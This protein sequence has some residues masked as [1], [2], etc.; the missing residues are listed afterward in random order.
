MLGYLYILHT[1]RDRFNRKL[2]LLLGCLLLSGCMSTHTSVCPHICPVTELFAVYEVVAIEKYRGGLT[3][4]IQAEALVDKEVNISADLFRMADAT[5]TQPS[6]Q[7][8]CHSTPN[9]GEV[10]TDRWSNFYGYKI[11]RRHI[12]VLDVFGNDETYPEYR[13]EVISDREL[14]WLHDGWLYRLRLS[15]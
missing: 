9:E 1:V 8:R 2:G 4:Q 3:T 6:Y 14:W 11:D 13:F 10:S 15:S 12:E 7:I 5:I